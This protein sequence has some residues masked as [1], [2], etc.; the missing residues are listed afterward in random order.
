MAM[1]FRSFHAI[2]RPLTTS[3]GLP[4]QAIYGSL[5]FLL[6]LI[7]ST[8]PD[9]LVIASDSKAKTFR[10]EM[11]PEYK[12]NRKEM[13]EELAAQIPHLYRLFDL[14]GLKTLKQDGLEAD[15]LIGSMTTKFASKD[16]HCL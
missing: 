15:D 2:S 6:Q 10:H 7:E 3:S 4:T 13:P 8:N 11:Y 14:L 1:A 9:Y 5:N 12:A 16:L